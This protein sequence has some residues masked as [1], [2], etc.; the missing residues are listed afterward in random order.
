MRVAEAER[1]EAQK[2]LA[3]ARAAH[4][5]RYREMQSEIEALKQKVVALVNLGREFNKVD[6]ADERKQ[7]LLED[8]RDGSFCK[9]AAPKHEDIVA[10]IDK[11]ENSECLTK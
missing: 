10:K 7:Q 5:E 4:S 1:D 11:K 8:V 6:S 2:N 9:N 3:E